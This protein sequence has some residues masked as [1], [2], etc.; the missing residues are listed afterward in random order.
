MTTLKTIHAPFKGD[1][2]GSFLR[3]AR[4]KE[5]REQKANGIISDEQLR[6]IEDEEITRL[7]EK[8][9]EAGLKTITDGDFRRAW[10][11]FDFLEGLEGVEGYQPEKGIQFKGVETKPYAVRV[12]N[13]VG[14]GDHPMLDHFRFL[15]ELVGKEHTAKFTIPSPNMLLFRGEIDQTIYQT[16]EELVHDLTRAYR[17]AIQAFY[18]LGC[19]YLQLDDTSWAGF[20]SEE[21]LQKIQD[22]GQ[23]PEKL[24]SLFVK[25]VND[26]IRERPEDMVI[27]MHICRGNYRSTYSASGSYDAVSEA[28][29]GELHVDGLF[30]EYDDERSGGFEPL[31]FV[32]RDDLQLVLGL[33]TTK[34][35]EL[36]DKERIKERI[37]EASEYV[38]LNQL[39][40]SPQCGF[41]STEEGNDLTEEEQWAKIRHVMEIAEEVWGLDKSNKAD[42]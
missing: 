9:K 6:K 12:V 24:R 41:A 7:V 36:E 20:F 27:T 10:W 5:A 33:I 13:K 42:E 17:Q 30:L 11:H 31:R 1:Q 8:Q 19:R 21:G 14:F 32:N 35:P 34:T 4:L 2:V 23:D 22:R 15:Q 40:L 3:P 16:E 26:S 29:F 39:C 18:D 25:A 37:A 28:I 38:P